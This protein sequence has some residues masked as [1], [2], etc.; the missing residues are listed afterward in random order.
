MAASLLRLAMPLT[1][2]KLFRHACQ[3]NRA[4]TTAG[5]QALLGSLPT[6]LDAFHHTGLS[7][8]DDV[9][10]TNELNAW[11]V[12]PEWDDVIFS[13]NSLGAAI[14]TT[15]ND[16]ADTSDTSTLWE[17]FARAQTDNICSPL[18]FGIKDTTHR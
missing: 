9:D 1:V 7:T 16:G 14:G 13:G 3:G 8:T 2:A 18:Q 12:G 5:V 17:V 10:N 15:G 4:T 6:L 11:Y